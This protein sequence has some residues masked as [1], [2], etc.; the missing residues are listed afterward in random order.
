M[1]ET[2]GGRVR[3]PASPLVER[4]ETTKALDA[5]DRELDAADRYDTD[6]T[7]RL[8]KALVHATQAIA[9]AQQDANELAEQQD[10]QLT[11][12]ADALEA[13]TDQQ[14]RRRFLRLLGR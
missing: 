7:A 11:R 1:T 5:S 12:I 8:L 3:R 4:G 14:P 13:L 9:R 2:I 6:T 10:Q